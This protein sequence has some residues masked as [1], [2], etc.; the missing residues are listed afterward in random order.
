MEHK[1]TKL[2]LAITSAFALVNIGRIISQKGIEDI[3]TIY[4]LSLLACGF[5]IGTFFISL[6][7]FIISKKNK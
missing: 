4:I 5:A 2:M 3:R 6:I 1:T 7:V